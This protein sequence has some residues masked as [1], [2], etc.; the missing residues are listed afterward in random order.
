[1]SNSHTIA[2]PA[3]DAATIPIQLMKTSNGVAKLRKF[4]S[5][6]SYRSRILDAHRKRV[7]KDTGTTASGFSISCAGLTLPLCFS[8]T[9]CF[10]S[11]EAKSDNAGVPCTLSFGALRPSFSPIA[12]EGVQQGS[13]GGEDM[14]LE[15]RARPT[16]TTGKTL[17][18]PRQL[19]C[20]CAALRQSFTLLE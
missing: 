14:E 5:V 10:S 6:C 20:P 9:E 4:R 8:S 2:A 13:T 19:W 16:T 7:L 11:R 15:D 3:A 1:M 18:N 12:R 17:Y